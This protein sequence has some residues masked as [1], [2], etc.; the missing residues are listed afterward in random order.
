[1]EEKKQDDIII[2]DDQILHPY[3]IEAADMLREMKK[4][5]AKP[6]M[7]VYIRSGLKKEEFFYKF[8]ED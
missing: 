4:E 1:M 2:K 8:G 5:S 3:I 7:I 6:Y